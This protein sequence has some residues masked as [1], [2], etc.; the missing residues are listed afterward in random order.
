MKQMRILFI[1]DIFGS[2]GR[3]AVSYQLSLWQKKY[4]PDVVIAN[5]ENA[6]HGIGISKEHAAELLR[7]GVHGMTGGNHSVENKNTLET[8]TD[9]SLPCLRPANAPKRVPGRGSITLKTGDN[10]VT[11][12]NLLGQFGIRQNFDS[13]FDA[14]DELLE[15]YRLKDSFIIVDFH[16][17]AT[18]EKYAM[19]YFLDGRVTAV[20]GTHTHV[21]TRDEQILPKGTAFITDVGMTGPKNSVIGNK[22]EH[23]IMR[24]AS[25]INGKVDI[26]EEGTAM[27]NAVL[28][29]ADRSTHLAKSIIHIS[30]QVD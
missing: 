2:L 30:S 17:E 12:I 28:I 9:D 18:S 23:S 8:L 24:L 26:E 20:V 21:A 11:V 16:A 15:L 29:E 5:V 10:A 4:F 13:P 19:G 3:R 7:L 27:I 1:G 22:I 14:V 25:Q 6:T